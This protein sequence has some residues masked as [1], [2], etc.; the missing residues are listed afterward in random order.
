MRPPL[1]GIPRAVFLVKLAD[2]GVDTPRLT[3]ADL[4][5]ETRLA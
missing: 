1:S 3:Q 5:H 4:E 2:Y